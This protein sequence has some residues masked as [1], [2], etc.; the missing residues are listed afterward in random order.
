MGKQKPGYVSP[1][2]LSGIFFDAMQ[3]EGFTA[4][5]AEELKTLQESGRFHPELSVAASCVFA[6]GTLGLAAYE[7]EMTEY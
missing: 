3:A 2:D 6:A 4:G 1:Q 7:F 5:K